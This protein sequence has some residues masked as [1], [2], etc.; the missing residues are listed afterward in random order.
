MLK[1]IK[2]IKFRG[3]DNFELEFGNKI[4]AI[5]G[6]NG[7]SKT[8]LLGM[9]AQVFAFEKRSKTLFNQNFFSEFGDNFKFSKEYEKFEKAGSHSYEVFFNDIIAKTTSKKRIDRSRKQTLIKN[10][11]KNLELLE[12]EITNVG[13]NNIKFTEIYESFEKYFEELSKKENKKEQNKLSTISLQKEVENFLK[14]NMEI[15]K[16]TICTNEILKIL[17]NIKKIE[18]EEWRLRLVT[19]INNKTEKILYPVIY[20]GLDRVFPLGA[21]LDEN[22]NLDSDKFENY[23]EEYNSIMKQI[24]ITTDSFIKINEINSNVKTNYIGETKHYDSFAVSIGQDNLSKIIWTLL[25]FKNLKEMNKNYQGGILLIDEIEA[26]LHPAAQKKLIEYL[27][28]VSKDLNLQIILTTHSVTIVEEIIARI[29]ESK[30][31]GLKNNNGKIEKVKEGNPNWIA[32]DLKLEAYVKKEKEKKKIN[33]YTEDEEARIIFKLLLEKEEGIRNNLNII[34]KDFS[35]NDLKKIVKYQMSEFENTFFIFDGDV[36]S[37]KFN[38]KILK[39]VAFLPGENCIEKELYNFLDS[40]DNNDKF[41]TETEGNTRYYTKEIFLNNKS[42]SIKADNTS[43]YKK[44]YDSEK[45]YFG[46][47][48]LIFK[49]WLE[50]NEEKFK[51]N[52]SSIFAKIQ[53]MIIKQKNI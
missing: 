5:C 27:Y 10:L 39:Q 21:I 48:N 49:R 18:K 4:T 22:I 43:S 52:V 19:T 36:A 1:K 8:T 32:N 2:I 44:W 38:E 46:K 26:S 20:L 50:V 35:K 25:S 42:N 51:K 33:I 40:L 30:I 41:W 11:K 17:S 47:D 14:N 16:I 23:L 13:K 29:N 31:I 53:E 9:I 28:K 6:R 24:F 3:F 7:S 45:K 15:K 34:E 37:E 12:K